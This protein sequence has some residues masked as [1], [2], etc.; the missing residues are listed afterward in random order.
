MSTLSITQQHLVQNIL[1]ATYAEIADELDIS[2]STARD[3]ISELKSTGVS[4]GERREGREKVFYVRQKAKEHPTNAN[5]SYQESI[6]QTQK[7]SRIITEHLSDLERR[8]YEILDDSQPPVADGG[9]EVRPSNEDLVIHR[10]DAHF[11]DEYRDEFDNLT[12]NSEIGVE[13][14]QITTDN[15]MSLVDRQKAAGYEFDTAHLLLGGDMVTGES[16]HHRQPFE[17]REHLDEQLDIA[18]EVYMNQIIRLSDA[19]PQVQV[20]CQPGNHGALKGNF[21]SGANAD[22]ILYMMLDKMVRFSSLDN[23]TF[24]RNDSTR[25][26]NFPLRA[27]TLEQAY[28]P[29]EVGHVGH[30]RHGDDSL[31]HIGTSAGKKRWYSWLLKHQFDIAYRGHYHKFEIDTLHG[32]VKVVMSGSVKP[33]G[34]FEESIAEWSTPSATMHGVS[35]ERPMT[36]MFPV[37]FYE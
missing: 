26:T 29:N 20:V 13:R 6:R 15:V 14:E 1:P 24:V 34:D 25:F 21:S 18:S 2:K 32:D 19:F 31:E 37:D 5:P 33:P 27:P 16:T 9:L 12:Y 30:L 23:V 8:L 4:I 7:K 17:I 36:F 35:D 22:R 3:H 10:T 28:D 11:G